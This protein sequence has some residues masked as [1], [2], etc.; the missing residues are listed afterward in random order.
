[1]FQ[2]NLHVKVSQETYEPEEP[3]IYHLWIKNNPMFSVLN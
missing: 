3:G 2:F 1:M